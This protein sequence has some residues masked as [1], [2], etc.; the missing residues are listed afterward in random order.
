MKPNKIAIITPSAG[1]GGAEK[2]STL[3]SLM[4]EKLNFEVHFIAAYSFKD[5]KIGGKFY[6]L[7]ISKSSSF[8]FFQQIIAFFKLRKYI[9]HHNFDLI[10]DFRSRRRFLIE[11]IFSY[12]VVPKFEKIIYTFHLPVM[13]KY[14][15]KP[16]F[17]FK[18]VYNSSKKVVCVSEGIMQEAKKIGLKNTQVIL[19]PIDFHF[20]NNQI[21]TE[22]IYDFKFI[23]G[24]GRMDDNVKQFDHLMESYSNSA[25]PKKNIH[26][27]ILGKGKHQLFCEK[28]KNNLPNHD[29]IHFEGFQEN[30]YKYINQALFFVLSSKLEGFPLVVLESLACSTPVVSYDCPT[31]P[32]EIIKHREN[33]IL[34][35]PQDKRKLTE[36]MNLLI[37][38]NYLYTY[39]KNN[40]KKSVEYLSMEN[41]GNQ[42]K[43]LI[44]SN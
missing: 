15:S 39:C 31:G 22:K 33:G 18:G 36:A 10:I 34:V 24:I 41:I 32:S 29:K 38:D 23:I 13:S 7:N 4:L 28:F 43:T 35:P 42:W 8:I 21:N 9:R 11:Y 1:G 19:N 37:E 27:L 2:V 30:P 17:L 25:L 12:F 3:L 16:W 26:L 5:F 44:E 40:A 14:I 20:I 6:C